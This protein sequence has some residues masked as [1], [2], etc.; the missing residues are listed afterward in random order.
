[1]N[2]TWNFSFFSGKAPYTFLQNV[3]VVQCSP[4]I[5]ING[6]TL[7]VV[8][9]VFIIFLTQVLQNNELMKPLLSLT[10]SNVAILFLNKDVAAL[11]ES[12]IS[13]HLL[14]ILGQRI[15]LK[16]RVPMMGLQLLLTPAHN[17]FLMIQL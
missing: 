9:H 7:P 6:C 12:V 8:I 2:S 11:E 10:L 1:M 3:P 15:P 13:S 4:G 17:L 5:Q 16:F 14:L